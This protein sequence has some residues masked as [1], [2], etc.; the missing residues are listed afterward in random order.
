MENAFKADISIIFGDIS[1]LITQPIY[2]KTEYIKN[3]QN[4]PACPQHSKYGTVIADF[5]S[6][7]DI[8]YFKL[9]SYEAPVIDAIIDMGIIS[10]QEMDGKTITIEKSNGDYCIKLSNW[11]MRYLRITHAIDQPL[12]YKKF[13]LS[14]IFIVELMKKLKVKISYQI[15]SIASKQ[16]SNLYR[17]A[18][19]GTSVYDNFVSYHES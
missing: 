3:A 12:D 2:R 13:L 10:E 7:D 15:P 17:L 14:R 18:F 11:I 8:N 6:L 5:L 9:E 16:T 19:E 4:N 1:F